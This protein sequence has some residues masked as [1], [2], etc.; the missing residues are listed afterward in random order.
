MTARINNGTSFVWLAPQP[1]SDNPSGDHV[2]FSYGHY[3]G[4]A[5]FAGMGYDSWPSNQHNSASGPMDVWAD[6]AILSGHVITITG[7]SSNDTYHVQ[8]DASGEFVKIWENTSTSNPP[9]FMMHKNAISGLKFELGGGTN[10]IY[11]APAVLD[12]LTAA[13]G[14]YLD[15]GSSYMIVDYDGASPITTVQTLLKSGRNNGTWD[16]AGIRSSAAGA[17]GNTALGFVE[18][19]EIF[20]TFPASFAGQLVDSTAV[21]VKYTYYGDTDLNG[22]VNLT[23]FNRLAANFGMTGRRW[24]EGDFN[25][26]TLVNLED[27]NLLAMNFGQSGMGPGGGGGGGSSAGAGGGSGGG[28]YG[29]TVEDL[30]EHLL[31]GGTGLPIP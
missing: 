22:N 6:R 19:T 21:L 26:D 2:P 28:T 11:V 3:N 7:A 30:L 8:M 12:Y 16:G 27:F 31:N 17:A 13:T 20:T 23:D 24:F 29:Y 1:I 18:A 9:T 15:A 5:A 10:V 4:N 25:Y 14:K